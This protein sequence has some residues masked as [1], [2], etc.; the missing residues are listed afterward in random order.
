MKTIIYIFPSNF[1]KYCNE[2]LESNDRWR[3]EGS[4]QAGTAMVDFSHLVKVYTLPLTSDFIGPIHKAV[5][6]R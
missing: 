1:Y 4:G 3:L 2:P 6:R 5:D